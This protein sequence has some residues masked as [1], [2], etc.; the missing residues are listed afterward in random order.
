MA[1][2]SF[3]VN[4]PDP[5]SIREIDSLVDEAKAILSN[6]NTQAGVATTKATEASSSANSALNSATAAQTSANNASSSATA[7]ST[8]A[9][10]AGTSATNSQNSAI[11]AGN[12]ATT[13]GTHATNAGN[14]ATA[15]G[16]SATNASNSATLAQAWAERADNTDVN[17]AGTRSARHWANQAAA[18]ASSAATFNPALYMTRANNLSDLANTA[19]ARTNLGAAAA[20]HTHAIGD[21]PVATSGT[22]STTQLVRADDS[23][24]SNAR[25]P[26]AHTHA[27]ADLPVATS[28]T[29][30]T[31]QLVRADDSR[32]SNARTPTAHTHA[33]GDITNLGT[34]LNARASLSGA[35]FTG[36]VT[37]GN[38]NLIINS[39]SSAHLWYRL[40][41]VNRA[42]AYRENNDNSFRVALYNT[43]GGHVRELA[44][45]E[46]DGRFGL[47]GYFDVSGGA[48]FGGSVSVAGNITSRDSTSHGYV[49][50][51]SGS[52]ANPGY[53][54][55]RHPNTTR[56]GFIGWQGNV[57]YNILN[58]EAGWGWQIVSPSKPTILHSTGTITRAL[59]LYASDGI[60]GGEIAMHRDANVRRFM[61]INANSNIEFINQAYNGIPQTFDNN[62]TIF[63]GNGS[64]AAGSD[65]RLKQDI[66]DARNQWED[67]KR[68][69]FRRYKLKAEVAEL[70]DAAPWHLGVIAQELQQISPELVTE[71]DPATGMLGVKQSVL[72]MKAV[73]ALQEAM[74]RLERTERK[75]HR[76]GQEFSKKRLFEQMTDAE[77]DT[78]ETI[79]RQQNKRKARMFRESTVLNDQDTN[80]PELV[81]VM[82]RAYGATRTV[83]LLAGAAI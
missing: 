56:V 71:M 48:T 30:S 44:F 53:I 29:S 67:V 6:V 59:E 52:T 1:S 5:D 58:G 22:S 4:N 37:A 17:G 20:S 46:S 9:T 25:T 42:L 66:S 80:F 81:T 2:S 73:V 43:S 31:T 16:T 60:N 62:G 63:S 45:R 28:G 38:G 10:N 50:L 12:S 76:E 51:V 26:T 19:T 3:F 57:G 14:S 40:N 47:S 69:R 82:T 27:I 18:S 55:F 15:A 78:W 68:F 72:L 39:A 13:A 23:R 34:E 24:L 64:F 77:Y 41:G 70:G 7:A 74:L 21:L 11:A 36:D 49:T 79:E 65:E 83:E 32:L 35:S 61:R 8:S 33:I 75:V 54:E